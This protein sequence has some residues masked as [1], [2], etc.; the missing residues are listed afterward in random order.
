MQPELPVALGEAVV[1]NW[2]GS[3]R[4]GVRFWSW[5]EHLAARVIQI[6]PLGGDW[7]VP[8]P[9]NG[10]LKMCWLR[11]HFCACWDAAGI[12]VELCQ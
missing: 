4:P 6:R 2:A 3:N 11:S 10:V 9:H 12:R 5:G 8:T 7:P 1:G